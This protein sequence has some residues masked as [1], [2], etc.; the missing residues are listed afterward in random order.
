M[1]DSKP[2][3]KTRPW[4][5]REPLWLTPEW[6]WKPANDQNC[7]DWGIRWL[8][9]QVWSAMSPSVGVT[10]VLIA[11]EGPYVQLN[12]IYHHIR[13]YVPFPCALRSFSYKYFWRKG[14]KR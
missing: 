8:W 4:Y 11:S 10:V 2:Y 6:H 13:V 7:C 3:A 5:S 9:L 14:N 12:A 1:N